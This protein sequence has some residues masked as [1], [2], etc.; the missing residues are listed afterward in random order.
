MWFENRLSIRK[1]R[2]EVFVRHCHFSNVSAHKKRFSNF[3]RESCSE[4]LLRTLDPSI[5]NVTYLLDTFY[6]MKEDHFIRRQNHSKIVEISEGCETGSFLRLLDH[7]VSLNLPKE[8]IIYLLE[9]DYLH[10]NNWTEILLEGFSL[11]EADYVTLY[12]HKDKYS[13]A[14]RDL[15]SKIYAT[16]SCHWR[17]VPSTTNTYAARYGTL[18]RDLEI[19]RA[20]SEGRKISAD[21]DKFVELGKKGV[22]LISSIPGWSTHGEPE[23]ASPCTDWEKIGS[24]F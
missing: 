22:T 24:N 2:I 7:V 8:T 18:L 13:E 4:N 3:S 1:P 20:F 16:R 14:Y 6:P 11:S 19:H 17:T 5:V 15:R 10:R 23:F 12:D 21:H 9:D